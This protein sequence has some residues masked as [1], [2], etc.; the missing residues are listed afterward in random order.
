MYALLRLPQ[1]ASELRFASTCRAPC[2]AWG[3]PRHMN[4]KLTSSHGT[5]RD[6]EK[7]GS[8]ELW[9]L[10]SS[11]EE[12]SQASKGRVSLKVHEGR[13]ATFPWV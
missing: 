5:H 2:S 13:R 12:I 1:N 8:G 9:S 7:F 3:E 10:P 4:R 11:E 6:W